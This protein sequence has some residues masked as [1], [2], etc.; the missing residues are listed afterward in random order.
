MLRKE[1][2]HV[3]ICMSLEILGSLQ[4]MADISMDSFQPLT[5][6]KLTMYW[7]NPTIYL[8]ESFNKLA[9]NRAEYG[10]SSECKIHT[11]VVKR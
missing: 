4:G 7:K 8:L 10:D 11:I 5:G 1:I 2:R 3:V 6:T 9:L